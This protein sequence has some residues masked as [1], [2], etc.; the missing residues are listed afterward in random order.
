MRY[1]T[2]TQFCDFTDLVRAMVLATDISRQHEFLSQLTFLLDSG[3]LDM[4]VS[5]RRHF[6]L[7][8]AI[9]VIPGS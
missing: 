9:K 8:I 1:L 5:H 3:D 7:Q 6:V 4:S 2:E